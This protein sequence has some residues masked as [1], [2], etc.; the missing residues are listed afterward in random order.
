M[1]ELP[2][3]VPKHPTHRLREAVLQGSLTQ[4]EFVNCLTASQG[5]NPPPPPPPPRER[6]RE[7]ESEINSHFKAGASDRERL[8]RGVN[9]QHTWEQVRER[10]PRRRQAR[11]KSHDDA[12]SGANVPQVS[13]NTIKTAFVTLPTYARIRSHI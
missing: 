3:L 6:E 4:P 11:E 9:P 12:L 13:I 2:D 8:T 1:L 5:T 10:A 7:R